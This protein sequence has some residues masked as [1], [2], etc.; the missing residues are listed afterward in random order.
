MREPT[1]GSFYDEQS[2]KQ[3]NQESEFDKRLKTE[4]ERRQSFITPE[5]INNLLPSDDLRKAFKSITASTISM[6]NLAVLEKQQ[7]VLEIRERN[8]ANEKIL[9]DFPTVYIGAGIDIEYPLSLGSRNII[10]VDPSLKEIYLIEELRQKIRN[11]SEEVPREDQNHFYF[12]FDFG[13]GKEDTVITID[14]RIYANEDNAAIDRVDRFMPPDKIGTILA[15]Q[16][17]NPAQNRETIEHLLPDGLILTN[18]LPAGFANE[19]FDAQPEQQELF[20]N[21][22]LN[23]KRK[24]FDSVYKTKGFESIQLESFNGFQTLLRKEK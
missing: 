9:K 14:P 20:S 4:A 12:K 11:L 24:M 13:K 19:Y 16:S 15:F 17:E 18:R 10:M 21:A 1:P 22:T 8:I 7:N 3:V 2:E 6:F 5:R 23:G